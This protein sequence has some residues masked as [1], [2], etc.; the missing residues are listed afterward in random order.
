VGSAFA[1][2]GIAQA[3]CKTQ[4]HSGD[5]VWRNPGDYGASPEL[6]MQSGGNTNF[7]LYDPGSASV[8]NGEYCNSSGSPCYYDP[9]E[10][11]STGQTN[12][13]VTDVAAGVLLYAWDDGG[14]AESVTL[15]FPYP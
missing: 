2:T 4:Q 15:Y 7:S 5:C 11:F 13:L 9:N 6:Y 1:L 3:Y 10:G 14:I 12:H 8:Y